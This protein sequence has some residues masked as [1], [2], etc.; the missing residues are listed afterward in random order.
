MRWR[1]MRSDAGRQRMRDERE[2]LGLTGPAPWENG[3]M[4][5]EG[6]KVGEEALTKAE[7]GIDRLLERDDMEVELEDLEP[8][9]A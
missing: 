7:E 1:V 3:W 2:R 6:E 5:S 4:E 8:K 9:T